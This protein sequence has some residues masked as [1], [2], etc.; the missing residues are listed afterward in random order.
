MMTD[1][2]GLAIIGIA[3]SV[4]PLATDPRD[5]ALR[6]AERRADAAETAGEDAAASFR[7]SERAATE[8]E[9]RLGAEIV[10]LAAEIDGLEGD[11]SDLRSSKAEF[12]LYKD[13]DDQ[14]RW[15]LVHDNGNVIA[16]SGEG[17]SSNANARKGLGSVRLNAFGAALDE[18]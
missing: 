2:T 17:Y 7:A 6:A 1:V 12:E 18:V 10:Q 13:A 9:E 16:D 4:I 15:R 3:G 5:T 14:W 8:R 11:H